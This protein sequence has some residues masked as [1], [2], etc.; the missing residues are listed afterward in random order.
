MDRWDEEEAVK[1][2]IN[3]QMTVEDL[4]EVEG[5]FQDKEKLES[6]ILYKVAGERLWYDECYKNRVRQIEESVIASHEAAIF[7]VYKKVEHRKIITD[8]MGRL[9][10]KAPVLTQQQSV[11]AE[12]KQSE[13]IHF[14]EDLIY[15][16]YSRPLLWWYKC[17][18]F[19]FA[20]N[21]FKKQDAVKSE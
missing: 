9:K 21:T 11:L 1:E 7:M 19:S 4:L 10:V 2:W 6:A 20:L 16:L 18:S 5:V 17:P 8:T 3:E 13:T 12:K 14:L 15:F